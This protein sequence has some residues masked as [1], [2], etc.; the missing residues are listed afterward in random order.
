MFLARHPVLD[1]KL[2]AA[3]G[4]LVKDELARNRFQRDAVRAEGRNEVQF[5]RI[6]HG[7]NHARAD[8]R[9]LP[10]GEMIIFDIHV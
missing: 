7:R 9:V 1:H 4:V 5:V 6:D 10:K 2:D 3:L 8:R